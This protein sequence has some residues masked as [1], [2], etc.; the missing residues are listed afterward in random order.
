MAGIWSL[1]RPA[2]LPSLRAVATVLLA[3]AP[4]HA[5]PL[6]SRQR[7]M[8]LDLVRS[9]P[10]ASVTELMA[11]MPFQ[12]G[13][14]SYHLRRLVEANLVRVVEDPTDGRRR[15]IYPLEGPLVFPEPPPRE[16]DLKGLGLSIA[17]AVA[18]RPGLSFAD[19]V[20]RLD[21][22]PRNIHYHLK[23]LHDLG[24]VTS[25][26]TNRY[27]DLRP[28]TRLLEILKQALAREGG[29]SFP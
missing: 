11:H 23:R 25:G 2:A 26:A 15:R 27:R 14:M 8:L 13:S 6:V 1:R 21:T 10:G 16:P 3:G 18:T 29:S 7:R 20:E 22:S 28:T 19:L 17:W 24:L 9:K 4:R 12:W 5:N